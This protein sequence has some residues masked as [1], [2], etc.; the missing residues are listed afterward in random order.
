MSRLDGARMDRADSDLMHT[1]AF[2]LIQTGMAL[3][4]RE[5]LASIDLPPQGEK[6]SRP[7][8]V[9][10]P[11]ALVRASSSRNSEQV[12]H[13]A[14][15]PQR[16]REQWRDT[17]IGREPLCLRSGVFDHQL[18][19]RKKISGIDARNSDR[20]RD[21]PL[22]RESGTGAP[23]SLNSSAASSH[24]SRSTHSRALAMLPGSWSDRCSMK[25]RQFT[26]DRSPNQRAAARYHS[27]SA[28]G[29]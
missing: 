29:I 17:R 6:L 11:S 9:A 19:C 12:M 15:H 20:G 8:A 10:Q 14:L 16:G 25:V 13:A 24:C 21:R 18:R 5:L 4:R 22:P 26:H 23:V 3:S 7:A 1:V 2:Y 27:A 28:G